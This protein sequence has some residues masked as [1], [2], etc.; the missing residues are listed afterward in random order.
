[1][2][3]FTIMLLTASILCLSLSANAKAPAKPVPQ[4]QREI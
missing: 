2:R 4:A 1:M 3:T